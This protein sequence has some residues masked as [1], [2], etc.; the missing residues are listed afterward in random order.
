MTAE[1]NHD[2]RCCCYLEL[3]QGPC[4][5]CPEHGTGNP[6]HWSDG[7]PVDQAELEAAAGPYAEQETTE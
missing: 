2:P 7:T 6:W 4:P 3:D 5:A 1:H